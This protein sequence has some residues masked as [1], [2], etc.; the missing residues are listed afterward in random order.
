M[1]K[2]N[3]QYTCNE[4]QKLIKKVCHHQQI[5]LYHFR[6]GPKKYTQHQHVALLILYAKSGKSL[7]DFIQFL[8]ESKWPKWLNLKD[9]PSKSTINNHFQRIGLTLIRILNLVVIRTR[10]AINY[11]IDSTGIDSYHASKHYE[12]RI[13]RTHRP[14]IKLSILAHIEKPYLIEDFEITEQHTH[15]VVH[16]KSLGKRFRKKNCIIYADKA[17][18]CQELMQ[19][20]DENNNLL[21][22]PI[23]KTSRRRPNGYLRK[24]VFDFFDKDVYHNGRNPVEMIMFLFKHNGIVIRAKKRCNK[25]KELA[26]KILAYNVQRLSKSLQRLFSI[27]SLDKAYTNYNF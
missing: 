12:K 23:K 7:R 1:I 3:N 22:C 8:Y 18:D 10:K 5:S 27:I 6:Y 17:Y 14:Y 21:Y 19:I 13:G 24:K 26:W 16:A 2:N 20:F 25:V 4:L 9:I 11:A 15:D